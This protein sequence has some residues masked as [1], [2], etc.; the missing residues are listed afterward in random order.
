MAPPHYDDPWLD[1]EEE[2]Q[3]QP[4]AKGRKKGGRVLTPASG[5][6][7]LPLQLGQHLTG[8]SKQGCVCTVSHQTVSVSD[9]HRRRLVVQQLTG[10]AVHLCSAGTGSH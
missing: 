1:D 9:S 2:D 5:D 8:A 3:Q 10:A 4:V 7:K 6:V